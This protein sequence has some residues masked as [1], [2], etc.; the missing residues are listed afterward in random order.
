ME[1]NQN[2]KKLEN[3]VP[4]EELRARYLRKRPFYFPKQTSQLTCSPT[5]QTTES[6]SQETA[7]AK[8]SNPYLPYNRRTGLRLACDIVLLCAVLIVCVLTIFSFAVSTTEIGGETF[9]GETQNIFDFIWKSD[10][11]IINQIKEAIEQISGAAT[12]SDNAISAISSVMKLVR[13]LFLLV[14]AAIVALKTIINL[15][16]SLYYFYNQE[17]SKLGGVAVSNIA[18]NL[19]VYVFFVFFGSISGG[20]GVDAYFVGYTVGKGM[21][22]GIL[23]GLALLIAATICTYILNQKNFNTE[24]FNKFMKV[25]TAGI[26][27]MC[28][29]V[30]LTFMRIYSIFI[31]VF[32]SSLSTAILSIQNGFEIKSLIFPVLNLFLFIVCININGRVTKG[33]TGAFKYLLFYGDRKSLD[34]KT[35]NVLEKTS[36]MSFIPIIILSILSVGAVYVLSNP[37]F[38]Y[39]WS[40]NIYQYLVYIFI[41]A[42]VA[43]TLLSVF[44]ESGE[45]RIS[46]SE[47]SS[48]S[49]IENITVDENREC[50]K[51]LNGNLYT[52]DGTTLIRYAIIEDN[53]TFTMLEGVT[54]IGDLAF[55]GSLNLDSIIIPES[56]TCIGNIAFSGCSSITSITIPKSVTS[57]GDWAFNGCLKLS[58]VYYTGTEAEW[59]VIKIGSNNFHLTEAT[60]HYNYVPKT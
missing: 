18:Q 51:F 46:N 31:Y 17:S 26:G 57:I 13:L 35:K 29:A 40:V 36:S 27:Y 7:K 37:T 6:G 3:D 5:H 12:D 45:M 2:N 20:V 38:G 8:Q 48:C 33:F 19:M 60:I 55:Y 4:L 58:D 21:T 28:V 47:F 32:S 44:S 54:C 25:L 9:Y 39:G 24:G 34:T 43:Q 56:V 42:S 52:K 49:S 16:K 11:S 53:A 50:Y 15:L 41:I 22:V 59:A 1:E 14:P 30:V 23:I 10:N